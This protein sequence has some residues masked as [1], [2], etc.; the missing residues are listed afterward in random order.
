MKRWHLFVL[1]VLLAA[2]SLSLMVYK[3][4][5]LGYPVMPAAEVE[6][7]II[8]ARLGFEPSGGAIKTEL[9][10]PNDPTG[11]S[12]LDENFVSRGYGL[13]TERRGPNR[14]A[15][16]TMRRPSGKQAL[17]YRATVAPRQDERLTE[18]VPA[19]SAAPE[20]D[21]LQAAAV[22]GILD[23]VR[24][25]SADIATFSSLMMQILA[26]NSPNDNVQLLLPRQ[27]S[28]E[29]RVRT[30]IFVLAGARIPARM[31]HGVRLI[32]GARNLVAEPWLEVNNGSRWIPIDPTNGSHGYPA[33]FLVWWYGDRPA[34]ET[35]RARS[36][37]LRFS[38]TQVMEQA[39]E[40]ASRQAQLTHSPLT[41]Y[42]LMSL[43]IHTQN[44]Y[45]TLLLVP[46]GALLIV[47]LRNII[48][49]QTFGTFMPVLIAL[50]FR[51]TD[52]VA[53]VVLFSVIVTLGLVVRF[54]L[55]QLKLLLV[56]RLAAV[57]IV[58]ILLMALISI[59]SQRMRFEMGLSIALFPMVIMAMTI[60]RM[61]IVWE[62]NGPAN[63]IKQGVGSL[64]VAA[65][66]YLTMFNE[67]LAHFV[68][69]FPES[70]LLVLAVTLLIGRYTGYRLTELTRFNT[71]VEHKAP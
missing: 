30:A 14:Y 49:I 54:Y 53:G 9:A 38:V 15:T 4:R 67:A 27:S 61:S 69:V 35:E 25:K 46:L 40:T 20:Y 1:V 16:W 6:N 3:V 5:T 64:I 24:S 19:L 52:L 36:V 32:D 33:D 17:Y 29:A 39:L 37:D 34:F 11:F 44:I 68:F 71:I 10:I 45:R 41:S 42:S 2:S 21:E 70:L 59:L 23:E 7:W 43:P 63:A 66:C 12:I 8:E 60:E 48:G 56:P 13:Q 57:V 31:A 65:A 55:E 18:A 47:V 62:E 58:V 50:A 51:E 22:N 28:V 26:S